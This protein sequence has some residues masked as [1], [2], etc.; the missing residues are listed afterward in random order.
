[1]EFLEYTLRRLEVS[2]LTAA[3]L[4]DPQH[5]AL[6][7]QAA[8]EGST[9]RRNTLRGP[10]APPA[11]DSQRARAHAYNS[12]AAHLGL[13]HRLRTA[14]PGAGDRLD[15][16]MAQQL[17][18]ALAV[19]RPTG[20]N[21]ATS[22]RTAAVAALVAATGRTVP[23]LHRLDVPGVD[24]GQPLPHLRLG[25]ELCPPLDQQTVRILRRWLD[26]RAGITREL[27]GSDPGYL[28]IPTKPGRPRGGVEP[29]KPGLTRAAVRP[30]PA[31]R[32][33]LSRHAGLRRTAAPWCSRSSRMRGRAAPGGLQTAA[34]TDVDGAA[35]RLR[36][37]C[38]AVGCCGWW[39]SPV[40]GAVVPLPVVAHRRT[41]GGLGRGRVGGV[42]GHA[43]EARNRVPRLCVFRGPCG[44]GQSV[45]ASLFSSRA[46][47][48]ARAVSMTCC[49][50]VCSTAAMLSGLA[51]RAHP[52]T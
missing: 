34:T 15:A 41:E 6:W 51:S 10:S 3:E 22:I 27:E 13:P 9:R 36:S 40:R 18:H 17:L 35:H 32:P 7:L 24:L 46:V 33:P 8:A 25:T 21:A 1:M 30:Y 37:R 47:R 11:Y 12:F 45:V 52:A 39:R 42:F 44:P 4:M 29:P 16:G 2:S 43:S 14:H 49:P 38:A 23:E 5:A 26:V 20:A 28:W 48:I 19:H 50:V 31:R